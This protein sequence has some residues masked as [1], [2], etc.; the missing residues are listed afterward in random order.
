[1][2][3]KSSNN[4]MYLKLVCLNLRGLE[5]LVSW[6]HC[7]QIVVLFSCVLTIFVIVNQ[8]NQETN[9]AYYKFYNHQHVPL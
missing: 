3:I 8:E 6:K 7:T 9:V 5:F 1:M 2:I 4:L